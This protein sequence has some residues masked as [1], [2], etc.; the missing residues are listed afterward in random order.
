MGASKAQ[1]KAIAKYKAKKIKRVPL[2]MRIEDYEEMKSA[3]SVAGESVNGYIK[4][5]IEMRMAAE[6][7]DMGNPTSV[8]DA[9]KEGQP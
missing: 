3:A 7:A 9:E 4:K 5:A 2:D 8:P 1:L 6:K